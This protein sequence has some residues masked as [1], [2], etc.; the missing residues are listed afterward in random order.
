MILILQPS[1]V[2]IPESRRVLGLSEPIL[3]LGSTHP[4]NPPPPHPSLTS[5]AIRNTALL[6]ISLALIPLPDA[7]SAGDVSV[8]RTL[9][10]LSPC[11]L[12]CCTHGGIV[13][14]WNVSTM[15]EI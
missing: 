1:R 6:P 4:D 10:H 8:V 13:W 5:P 7:T 9:G 2:V 12:P 15:D 3:I 11:V 14:C